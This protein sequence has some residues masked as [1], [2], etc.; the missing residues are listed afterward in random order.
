MKFTDFIPDGLL[1][2]FSKD[3]QLLRTSYLIGQKG[4]IWIDTTKPYSLYNSIPQLKAVIDRKASMFSNM[5]LK[6][7]EV[8]TGKVLEDEQ[9]HKLLQNPN[10]LQSQNEWLRDYKQQHQ[11]YGNQ[12][13][14]KNKP[15]TLSKYPVALWNISPY[16]MKPI[17][18][19]KLF[20]Q[21]KKEDIIS[22]YQ[23]IDGG[24]TKTFNGIDI[25]FTKIADI[26][27]PIIGV[28]PIIS[29]KFPLTNTKLAYEYRNVIMGEK[30]AIGILSNETKDS[31]GNIAMDKEERR[32]LEQ[33]YRN[34]YGISP[35]KAKVILTNASLK[36]QPM[37]Y[38]TR[39]LLLFEEVEANMLAIIDAFGMSINLFSNKN[40]TFE[41]VK[42]SIIQVYQDTIIPEADLFTQSLSLFLNIPYGQRI[43][44]SYEHLSIMK[45][46]KLKGMTSI[47]S[48]VSSLTQSIHSGLLSPIQ[49][50]TILANELG[51]MVDEF[52]G[53]RTLTNLNRL[54][55]LVSNNVLGAMTIN[56][57][58]ALVGLSNIEGGDS[59][60][61]TTQATG[62]F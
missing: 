51:I 54:S 15:S 17:L 58:R 30:G 40:A 18:T 36:W 39:D 23:F 32:K 62:G 50:E 59:F 26:D 21:V 3:G 48:I 56:E 53:N 33:Q 43:V 13:I 6:L 24:Q 20:E 35:D 2:F 42:N 8:K 27:N 61:T 9:L 45:E 57:Q 4:A 47:E 29:L 5:E 22:E 14:Y 25:M 34:D 44:A 10:P 46:N 60:N 11:V 31:M 12:F 55:P 16:Y 38:P 28:S 52:S 41:N 37:T 49:A 7:I 19:G 1:N